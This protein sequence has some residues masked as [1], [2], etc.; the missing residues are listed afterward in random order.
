MIMMLK[1]NCVIPAQEL[2]TSAR[3]MPPVFWSHWSSLISTKTN[4]NI[5]YRESPERPVRGEGGHRV[6]ARRPEGFAL[7]Q[8]LRDPVLP[9]GAV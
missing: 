3:S 8:I 7:R 1:D 2:Q 4:P 9:G 5:R 6:Q